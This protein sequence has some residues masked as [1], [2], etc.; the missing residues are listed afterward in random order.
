LPQMADNLLFI[1]V[2]QKTN[3]LQQY[4]RQLRE[5]AGGWRGMNTTQAGH[6]VKNLGE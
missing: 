5:A 6:L 1:L 3:P 2:Y 4:L